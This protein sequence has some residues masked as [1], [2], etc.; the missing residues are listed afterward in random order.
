MENWTYVS[1]KKL[2][3]IDIP[4]G[5]DFYI[6]NDKKNLKIHINYPEANMQK[7]EAAFEAWALIFYAKEKCNVTLSFKPANWDGTFANLCVEQTHYIRFLYRLWKFSEQQKQWFHIDEE[8]KDMIKQFIDIFIKLKE[9]KGMINNIPKTEAKLSSAA[10]RKLEH[11]VENAFVRDGLDILKNKV[12]K[13]TNIDTV[14]NQLPNGLFQGKDDK[15]ITEGNRIFP[16]GF[17]DLWGISKDK[18][19]CIFELKAFDETDKNNA[20]NKKVGI[21][22]ELFFYANYSKDI[23]YDKN[24]HE[25]SVEFR[26]YDHLVKASKDGIKGIM[27]F[28]L[29]P[30]YH[31]RIADYMIEIE[32]FLNENKNEIEYRFLK[33]NYAEIKPYVEMCESN[34]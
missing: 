11:Y 29:A 15:D 20:K 28:F 23:F 19:L 1:G 5:I 10:E 6:D 4:S 7:D 3:G 14:Y 27:A 9:N 21:I 24:F 13:W 17:F 12:N 33:Y 31:S 30:E 32:K 22:S 18:E 34:P 8:N 16:T 26:G 25:E 2:W